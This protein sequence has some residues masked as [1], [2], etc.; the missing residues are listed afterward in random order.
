MESVLG[1]EHTS[2]CYSDVG[3][4]SRAYTC[5]LTRLQL[6]VRRAGILAIGSDL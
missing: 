6:H 2:S 4:A 1:D 5:F 3:L